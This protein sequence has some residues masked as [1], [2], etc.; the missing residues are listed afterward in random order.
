MRIAPVHQ[1]N[2]MISRALHIC[3]VGVPVRMD[4]QLI[5]KGVPQG[6]RLQKKVVVGKDQM[7]AG[8]M[9][10]ALGHV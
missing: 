1:T 6:V 5:V 9:I 3:V 4:V 7:V 10:Q 2:I 8:I